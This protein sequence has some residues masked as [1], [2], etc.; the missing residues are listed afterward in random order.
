MAFSNTLQRPKHDYPGG[1]AGLG[2]SRADTDFRHS[3]RSRGYVFIALVLAYVLLASLFFFSQRQ[4]PLSQ[5]DEYRDIQQTQG[6]L[7]PTV[8]CSK[9]SRCSRSSPSGPT[10]ARWRKFSPTCGNTT[11]RWRNG[12]RGRPRG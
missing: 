2:L 5:L 11:W 10:M 7:I 6:A 12:F 4:P 3:L 9:R 1:K 8:P